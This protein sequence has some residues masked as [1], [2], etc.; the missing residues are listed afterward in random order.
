MSMSTIEQKK[1]M[2]AEAF[3]YLLSEDDENDIIED[4][5]SIIT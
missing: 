3:I 5:T 1:D 4:F 2:I